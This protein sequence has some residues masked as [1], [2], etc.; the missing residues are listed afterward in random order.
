[1]TAAMSHIISLLPLEENLHAAALQGVFAATPGYYA[2]YHLPGAPPDQAAQDFAAQRATPGRH[3]LGIV[4]RLDPADVRAGAEMIGLID[5]RLHWPEPSMVY[6]G[7]LM[8]AE[9]FQRQG[10]ATQAW[11]LLKAWLAAS[12]GMQSARVGVEQFN[13]PCLQ[14]WQSVGLALTGASSRVRVGDKFVRLLF[15]EEI[16]AEDDQ[17]AA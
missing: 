1:M 11:A 13:Q 6:I 8:V 15:L 2:L 10:V 9:P 5:F 16:L 7:M 14:F 17:S 3:L 12:A 4:R